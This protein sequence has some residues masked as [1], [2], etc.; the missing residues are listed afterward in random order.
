MEIADRTYRIGLAWEWPP[1]HTI[2]QVDAA[3]AGLGRVVKHKDSQRRRWHWI[4]YVADEPVM[5]AIV[6]RRI[7]AALKEAGLTRFMVNLTREAW[8]ATEDEKENLPFLDRPLRP[9][10]SERP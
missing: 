6:A 3:I 7:E 4:G 10:S 5:V 1:Q 9:A 2:R 8:E